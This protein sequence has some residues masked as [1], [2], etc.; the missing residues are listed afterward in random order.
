MQQCHYREETQFTIMPQTESPQRKQLKNKCR[1]KKRPCFWSKC[2]VEKLLA[3]S[4]RAAELL[5]QDFLFFTAAARRK[6]RDVQEFQEVEESNIH[7]LKV[8][9]NISLALLNNCFTFPPHDSTCVLRLYKVDPLTLLAV[10]F[11]IPRM[12]SCRWKQECGAYTALSYRSSACT[13]KKNLYSLL[14]NPAK[15]SR[16]RGK[17]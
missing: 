8:L 5:S 11:C 13:T 1:P 15:L 17:V 10:L 9:K 7:S 4:P 3:R 14:H 6:Q 2:H 16:L 12:A